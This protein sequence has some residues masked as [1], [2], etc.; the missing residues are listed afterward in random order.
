MAVSVWLPAVFSVALN[1]P[2]AVGQRGV[3]RQ[4]RRGVA[5]GEVDRARVARGRIVVRVLR[6]HR[7]SEG[8]ARRGAGGGADHEVRGR[9]RV[10]VTAPLAPAIVAVDGIRGRHRLAARRLQRDAERARAV[11]QRGVGRQDRRRVAA[12]EVDRA[13]VARGRVVVRVFR[14]DRETEGAARRGAGGGADHEVRGRRRRHGHRAAG[15]AI[16]LLA[17]IRGRNRL[18]A[19]RLE[20]RR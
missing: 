18:A 13:R 19:G 11:G 9:R 12:G 1:V 10:T 17:R 20:R 5:A 15:P 14:R 4:D 3:G 2:D 8:A 7:E 6:R 16:E